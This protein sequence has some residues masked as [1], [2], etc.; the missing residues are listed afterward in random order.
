M[1]EYSDSYWLGVSCNSKGMAIVAVPS[2]LSN[3]VNAW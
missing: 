1:E 2:L 3:Q